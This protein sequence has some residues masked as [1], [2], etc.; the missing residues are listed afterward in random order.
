MQ[1]CTRPEYDRLRQTVPVYAK[2]G[3]TAPEYTSVRQNAS[4]C[5]RERFIFLK[6]FEIFL[7]FFSWIGERDEGEFLSSIKS[8]RR[9]Q[10]EGGGERRRELVE[11]VMAAAWQAL[12]AVRG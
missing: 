7:N 10:G 12:V 3:Q 8:D 9:R 4:E 1:E 2:L 11:W 6:S 5:A